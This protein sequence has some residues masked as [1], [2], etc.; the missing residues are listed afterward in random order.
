MM[1]QIAIGALYRSL[2][3]AGFDKVYGPVV[4]VTLEVIIEE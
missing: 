3:S 4:R 2:W 1:L